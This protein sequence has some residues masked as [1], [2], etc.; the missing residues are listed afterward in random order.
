MTTPTAPL[1][2]LPYKPAMRP[3]RP[4]NAELLSRKDTLQ[5][6]ILLAAEYVGDDMANEAEAKG[7][8]RPDGI[9]GYLEMVARADLKAFCGLLGRV[10]PLSLKGEGENGAITVQI[11]RRPD[12]V[13]E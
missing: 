8:T 3:R 9:M 5:K 2:P 6:A 10:L 12:A 13:V 4:L 11:V 1:P 7:E